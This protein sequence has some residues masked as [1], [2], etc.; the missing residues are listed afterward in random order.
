MALPAVLP[1]AVPLRDPEARAH[2]EALGRGVKPSVAAGDRLI[3]VTGDLGALL[4][5]GGLRRGSVVTVGGPSGAG[6]TT[7]AFHLAA[8][9][10]SA[11]EWVVFVDPDGTLGGRAAAECGVALDRCAVVRRV[12]SGR[13]ATV[14]AALLDGMALVAAVT[15]PGLRTGDARRLAARARERAAVLVAI[16]PPSAPGTGARRAV[17][18]PAEAALRLTAEGSPWPGLQTS[19]LLTPRGLRV[20][21]EDRGITRHGDVPLLVRAG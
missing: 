1:P 12:P 2:L 10:T 7:L 17:A 20:R 14:V 21:V 13:W 9:A 16:E 19:G 15:G 11:G 6:G 3:P 5:G 18:W 8:A 4:P